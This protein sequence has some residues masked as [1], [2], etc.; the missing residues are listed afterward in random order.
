MY[1]R[2]EIL[3]PLL[4]LA[5][6]NVTTAAINLVRLYSPL[7][8][9]LCGRE[10][11]AF[12]PPGCFGLEMKTNERRARNGKVGVEQEEGW[13]LAI[14]TCQPFPSQRGNLSALPLVPTLTP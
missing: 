12:S 13:G 4:L 8:L 1:R 10:S 9:L 5:L 7:L 11:N 6:R 3:P 14:H 2:N